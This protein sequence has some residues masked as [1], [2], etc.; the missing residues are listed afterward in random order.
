MSD[1]IDSSELVSY[2]RNSWSLICWYIELFIV[3]SHG[4]GVQ[5][6]CQNSMGI[7]GIISYLS[8]FNLLIN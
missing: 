7:L 3:Y 4:V 1:L 8:F 2:D 6:Y 5:L